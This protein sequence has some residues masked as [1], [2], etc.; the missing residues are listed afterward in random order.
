MVFLKLYV[1]ACDPSIAGWASK[2]MRLLVC[3]LVFVQFVCL[4]AESRE[5]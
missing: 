5:T 2:T 4:H 1:P 3:P